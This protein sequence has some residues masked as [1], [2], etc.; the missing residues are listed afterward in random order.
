MYFFKHLLACSLFFALSANLSSHAES[1]QEKKVS[2]IRELVDKF[3]T[4][5]DDQSL[6]LEQKGRKINATLLNE[7]DFEWGARVALGRY[8]REFSPEEQRKFV[9]VYRTYMFNVFLNKINKM[10]FNKNASK[11]L[12]R[13]QNINDIDD[14]I[15]CRFSTKTDGENSVVSILLRVRSIDGSFRILNGVF[16]GI[17]ISQSKR[18]EF[19]SFIAKNGLKELIPYMQKS[20]K[21]KSLVEETK[22][23]N[24]A[25]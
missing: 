24:Q 18:T 6:S 17:D 22:G 1:I 2:Y 12:N 23:K 11:V 5:Q 21:D 8:W 13:V 15:E 16:E 10:N 19:D 7:I 3:I 14:N 4:I 25:H 20:S 9:Q